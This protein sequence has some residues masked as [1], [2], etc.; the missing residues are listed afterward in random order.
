MAYDVYAQVEKMYESAGGVNKGYYFGLSQG[1]VQ[2]T[3]ALALEG[4]DAR[5]HNTLER[6][7]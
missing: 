1:T 5:L 3:I 6:V 4:G 2:M 7:I